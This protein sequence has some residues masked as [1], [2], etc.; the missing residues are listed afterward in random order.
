MP[1]KRDFGRVHSGMNDTQGPTTLAKQTVWHEVCLLVPLEML[2]GLYQYKSSIAGSLQMLVLSR[3]QGE[4][5]VIGDDIVL[6]INKIAGN[7]VT[8]AIE[9]PHDVRIVRGE[10]APLPR[11]EAGESDERAG[12]DQAGGDDSIGTVAQMRINDRLGL[13]ACRAS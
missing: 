8:I 3:K 6:I 1:K 4:R 13:A 12:I 11:I 10:L 2:H 5:L 7:R 9:A